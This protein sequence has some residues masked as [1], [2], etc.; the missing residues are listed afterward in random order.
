[1]KM[2]LIE[3]SL[4]RQDPDYNFNLV[5]DL[6]KKAGED[7]PD[8]MVLP[9][10]FNTGAINGKAIDYADK[11][12]SRTKEVISKLA[13]NLSAYII[14]GSI[15][16]LRGDDLYNT[17]YVFDRDGKQVG[18]YDKTHLYSASGENDL[19]KA[20]NEKLIF[21]I[22]GIKCGV[23]IC[24]DIEFAPWVTSYALDGVDIIFNPAAW[25]EDWIINYDTL[26][27]SRAVENQ[28]FVVGVNS[29]GKSHIG[30][31]GG[32]S[33]IIGPMAN[34]IISPLQKG[35]IKTAEF[36]INEAQKYKETFKILKDRREDLYKEIYK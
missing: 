34:Y 23:V 13:D 27:R 28:I 26:L 11:N 3:P 5:E 10:I 15:L 24:Y 31:F 33:Q 20:G 12:G 19:V 30:N 18:R 2:S 25:H 36:D 6:I 29:T 16:D 9:E 7:K 4:N 35:P 14:A 21:E 8:V 1:M 32:H 17:S 22:D